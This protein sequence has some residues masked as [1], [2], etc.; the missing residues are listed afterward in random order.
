MADFEPDVD[1]DSSVAA[2]D[3]S[4][5]KDQQLVAPPKAKAKGKGRPK[6]EKKGK[7]TC[8]GCCKIVDQASF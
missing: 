5:V 3:V 7:R 1:V 8:N 4:F 6:V 2:E